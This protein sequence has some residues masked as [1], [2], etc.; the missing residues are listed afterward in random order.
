VSD[1]Q[2]D[3]TAT[4]VIGTHAALEAELSA[5]ADALAASDVVVSVQ[6]VLRIEG[7]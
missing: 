1:D 3:G 2:G 4:L 5:T 7:E 6:S